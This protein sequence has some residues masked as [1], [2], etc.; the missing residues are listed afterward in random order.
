MQGGVIF[1][2]SIERNIP[3]DEAVP[4]RDRLTEAVRTACLDSYIA[5]LPLGL[6]TK[7]GAEGT[8]L[9]QGQKQRILIARAIYRNPD[10]LLLDEATNSL[11]A[12]NERVITEGLRP[13]LKGRTAVV[14]AHRLSTVRDAEN[15]GAEGWPGG[16]TGNPR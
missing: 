12:F 5:S 8:G 10:L 14:V 16:G 3:C 15:C 11:D 2:D 1:S 7:I 4:D 13:V 6:N 9:S